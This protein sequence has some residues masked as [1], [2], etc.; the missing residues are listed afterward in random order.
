MLPAYFASS[1]QNRPR[2]V[3]MT[4]IFAAG[5]GTVVLP[6]ALGAS[7]LLHLINGGH[8]PVYVTGGLLMGALGLYTLAGGRID[9]PSPG[10]GA[11]A[12]TGPVAVYSLGLFSGL[13]SSCCAP[14]LAGLVAL[15]GINQSLG[16]ALVFGSAYVFG[17]VLP[18][19]VI[20]L[21]WEMR[22]WR[23][24]RL[25]RARTVSWRLGPLGATIGAS[26]LASGVLLLLMGAGTTWIGLA[27][28]SM[29]ASGDW[30]ARLTVELQQ[31]GQAVTTTLARLPNWVTA[32]VLL[33]V[34]GLLAARD[35]RQLSGSGRSPGPISQPPT[36]AE[37]FDHGTVRQAPEVPWCCI[38]RK[39]SAA[40]PAGPRSR[41]SS[42]TSRSSRPWAST[43]SSRSPATPWAP[44][45]RRRTWR[46]SRRPSSPIP[47][48]ASPARTAPTSTG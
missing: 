26:Q 31:G 18:L 17:M 24:S 40:S 39:A 35:W 5:I 19:F 48:C 16:L 37:E 33:A 15:S 28:Q 22:D 13:A 38:S 34:I 9:L 8:T 3:A 27:G 1:F 14:V 7:A 41:T 32:L 47:A 10:R 25:F 6:I 43:R 36:A 11:S 21:L 45:S 42:P 29:P 46:G 30:Q 2:L 44:S 23:T 20:S 4:F 12:G